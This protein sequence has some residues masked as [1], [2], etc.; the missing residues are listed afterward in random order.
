MEEE[1]ESRSEERND[2]KTLWGN[3]TG[4]RNDSQ[5]IRNGQIHLLLRKKS[6]K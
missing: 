3:V 1:K 2:Q 6:K 4:G 5:S